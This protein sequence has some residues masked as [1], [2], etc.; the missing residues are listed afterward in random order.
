MKKQ[1]V[2]KYAYLAGSIDSDGS[3]MLIRWPSHKIQI[4]VTVSDYSPK[5]IP[6]IGVGGIDTRNLKYL[7]GMFGGKIEGG[8][9]PPNRWNKRPMF[10]WSPPLDTKKLKHLLKNLIPFLK[11]KKRKAELL[12]QFLEIRK[13]NK[14]KRRW[15]INE[16]G[17]KRRYT[18]NEIIKME[19]IYQQMLEETKNVDSKLPSLQPQ[20][21]SEETLILKK[22]M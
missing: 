13:E 14:G 20:R 5:Y 2:A 18:I 9:I 10:N 15:I 17:N 11:I 8:K 7:Y 6:R 16:N 4:D 12:L 1:N 21:L 3:I 22:N 19:K